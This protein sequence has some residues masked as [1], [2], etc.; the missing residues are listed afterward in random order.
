MKKE[1]HYVHQLLEELSFSFSI[2][3][4]YI[5]WFCIPNRWSCLSCEWHRIEY[6]PA[7]SLCGK[8]QPASLNF[9]LE[10]LI[11]SSRHTKI[12]DTISAAVSCQSYE[13]C[14]SK[15][16]LLQQNIAAEEQSNCLWSPRDQDHSQDES[17][18]N[19][20]RYS[21]I[22]TSFFFSKAYRRRIWSNWA[23]HRISGVY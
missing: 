7:L 4:L 10:L 1:N 20:N 8:H 3:V 11:A 16:E 22:K 5:K 23:V 21:D 19:A 17:L 18:P 12:G 6:S 15:S 13:V 14:V 2:Y 9:S